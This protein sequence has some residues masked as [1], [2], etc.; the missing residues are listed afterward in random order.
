M[1]DR[2]QNPITSH[3]LD[4]LPVALGTARIGRRGFL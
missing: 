3:R 2:L 1:R 4:R